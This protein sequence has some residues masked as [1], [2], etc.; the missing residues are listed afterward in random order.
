[1]TPL[2]VAAKYTNHP[3][4]ITTL[5]NAGTDPNIKFEDRWT[6]LHYAARYSKTPAVI[7]TLI[8]AGA[9]PNVKTEKRETP[10]DLL[11]SN[12]Y[13]KGSDASLKLK[14]SPH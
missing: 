14:E 6:P 13:L 10:W 12:D 7:T 11:Q 4:V 9:D 3:A 1:M 2:H 5:I 8:N